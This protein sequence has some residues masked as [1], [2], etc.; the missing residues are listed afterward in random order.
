MRLRAVLAAVAAIGATALAAAPAQAAPLACAGTFS[1]LHDDTIGFVAVP[2]GSY[3]LTTLDPSALSCASA[4]AAFARFLQDFDGRLPSP[5]QLNALT[6]TFVRGNGPA[7]FE[8][9]PVT[10]PVTPPAG[11]STTYPTGNRCPGTFRVLHDD[12]VGRLRMPAGRYLITLGPS[13]PIG[14]AATSRALA[15]FLADPAGRLPRAWRLAPAT[16]TFSRN[17]VVA[18]RIK[19]A[20]RAGR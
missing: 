8:V 12:R 6:G 2:A 18:F 20:G 5:W 3:Q 9:A 14:C 11:G 17:G 19:P 16:G 15:R 4:T 7:A 13:K 1:V 10:T